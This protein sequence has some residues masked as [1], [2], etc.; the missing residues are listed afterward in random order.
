MAGALRSR[1]PTCPTCTAACT[2]SCA[3]GSAGGLRVQ[4]GRLLAWVRL[5]KAT[6]E[7][8]VMALEVAELC[9]FPQAGCDMEA[10]QACSQRALSLRVRLLLTVSGNK[11]TGWEQPISFFTSKPITTV[12]PRTVS[13]AAHHRCVGGGTLAVAAC[14][15]SLVAR[16]VIRTFAAPARG[17]LCPTSGWFETSPS[18]AWCWRRAAGSSATEWPC[19]RKPGLALPYIPSIATG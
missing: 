18:C 14:H 13:S 8:G 7:Q 19:A 15:R 1:W 4:H 6:T 3:S 12:S 9:L 10:R 11:S 16:P 5:P 17:A 2:G